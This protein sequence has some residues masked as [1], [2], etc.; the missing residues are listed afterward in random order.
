[1][2]CHI[3]SGARQNPVPLL[4]MTEDEL[5]QYAQGLTDTDLSD[6]SPG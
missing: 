1:M 5:R 3:S 2:M 6:R 4:S